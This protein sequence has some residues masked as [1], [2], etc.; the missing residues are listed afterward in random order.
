MRLVLAGGIE[1]LAPR[2]S[3]AGEFENFGSEFEAPA[4]AGAASPLRKNA[5]NCAGSR[6][7]LGK[8]ATTVSSGVRIA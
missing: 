5:M 6:V 7:K 2:K 3:S 8:L 1:A 4:G